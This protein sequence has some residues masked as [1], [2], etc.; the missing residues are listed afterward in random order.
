MCRWRRRGLPQGR[1]DVRPDHGEPLGGP[2]EEPQYFVEKNGTAPDIKTR[3][4]VPRSTM[5]AVVRVD[6]EKDA[7]GADGR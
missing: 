3:I 6:M 5:I 4:D 7:I 1:R 2:I